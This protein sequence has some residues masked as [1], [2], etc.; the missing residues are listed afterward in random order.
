[1][2]ARSTFVIGLE[3][4]S[5]ILLHVGE[6]PLVKFEYHSDGQSWDSENGKDVVVQSPLLSVE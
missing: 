4:V 2:V 5:I 3:N 6:S 1:M